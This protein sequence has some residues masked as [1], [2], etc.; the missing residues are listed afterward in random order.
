MNSITELF[1][2]TDGDLEIVDTRIEGMVKTL[3]LEKKLIPHYCPSCQMRMYSRGIRKRTINHSILQDN[4]KLVLVLHQRRWKCTNPTCGY[5]ANEEFSF[6]GKRR[7]STNATD[8]LIIQALK[9]FSMPATAIAERFHTTDTFVMD[10][11]DRYVKMSRLTLPDIISIDEV[12]IDMNEHCKY[13]LVILDFYTGDPIDLLE[14]RRSDITEPYFTNI[15]IEERRQVKYLISDMYKP[16]FQ[17]V[18]KYFPNAVSVVD[19]F[20]VIQWI[21]F[22]ID[23]YIRALVKDFKKRDRER[24]L[25]KYPELAGTDNPKIPVSDEVYLLNHYRWLILANQENIIYHRDSRIDKHFHR[26]MNTY[27][28]EDSLFRISPR[29]RTLRDLKELYITF[30]NNYAGN[31]DEARPALLELIEKYRSSRDS[32]FIDFAGTLNNYFDYIINS[33]VMVKKQGPGGLYDAR[34]S[35]GPIESIN[36]AVKDIRRNGR[37]YRNFEHFRNRFLYGTRSNPILD[38]TRSGGYTSYDMRDDF[39]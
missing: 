19:S 6:V 21:N 15:P 30:N 5:T 18:S 2:L 34:L 17:L 24:F 22:K 4:Y 13:A 27:D 28:Y 23:Q 33:F 11:F 26:L 39:E 32:I 25:E 10:T 8:I 38:A 3:F 7:R 16:Y 31:P 36:R 37:G 29:L 12:C 9:D 20:H 14:S 1:D 35:N